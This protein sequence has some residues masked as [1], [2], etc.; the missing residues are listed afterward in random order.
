[1]DQRTRKAWGFVAIASLAVFAVARAMMRPQKIVA[2]SGIG[3]VGD[4][5][6][7]R[8][9]QKFMPKNRDHKGIDVD[10]PVGS[11]IYSVEDGRVAAKWR[12]G[13]VSGYGNSYVIQHPDGTQ[14]LYAHLERFA[15]GIKRGSK[16]TQGQLIGYVGQTQKPR[17]KM[18]SKPHL[19]FEI[20]MAHTL[21]INPRTPKRMDPMTYLSERGMSV[22]A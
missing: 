14:A 20:H 16:V 21:R 2:P 3:L 15:D 22:T 11:P 9:G 7:P 8:F 19:H 12:D 18:R 17:P 5:K 4:G 10:A 13:T 1:M 6:T